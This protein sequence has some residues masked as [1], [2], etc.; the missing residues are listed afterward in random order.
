MSKLLKQWKFLSLGVI[1]A[2]FGLMMASCVE[3]GD[4]VDDGYSVTLKSTTGFLDF[5]DNFVVETS[6]GAPMQGA[7]GAGTYQKDSLVEIYAGRAPAGYSFYGWNS[8]PTVAFDNLYDDETAFDMPGKD[9]ALQAFFARNPPEAAFVRFSWE[10]EQ[11]PNIYMISASFVDVDYWYTEVYDKEYADL[12]DADYALKASHRPFYD[13]N[14][15]VPNALFTNDDPS[16]VENKSTYFGTYAGDFTAICTA[17]DPIYSDTF[18]IVANYKVTAGT[19]TAPKY[20][21]IGFDVGLWIDIENTPG[22]DN[23]DN[24]V[25]IS[26]PST[27]DTKPVLE[28]KKAAKF[29]KKAQKGDVTYYVFKRAKK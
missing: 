18:D 25:V 6:N 15:M 21:E 14:Y 24:W 5:Y 17:I 13:G 16:N 4:P 12:D 23:P 29:L 9:V 2:A 7:T 3:T 28:K 22:A 20:H 26:N 19:A 1:V 8:I 11:I 27:D 10:A